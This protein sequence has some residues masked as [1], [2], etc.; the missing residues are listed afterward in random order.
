MVLLHSGEVA[1]DTA[2]CCGGGVC[3]PCYNCC[4]WVS[5]PFTGLG[6]YWTR[7]ETDCDGN[8]TYSGATTSCAR[9]VTVVQTKTCCPPEEGSSVCTQFQFCNDI[10][11]GPFCDTFTDPDCDDPVVCTASI[12]DELF[13]L[14]TTP[15]DLEG[16]CC[17]AGLCFSLTPS[18]CFTAG[19]VWN[20]QCSCTPNP[21]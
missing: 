15:C 10:G 7:V 6:G 13:D 19:G 18:D 16:P 11:F 5:S 14:V 17:I 20:P 1:T 21:C 3:E 2:C 4:C 12:V 9:Y 8:A